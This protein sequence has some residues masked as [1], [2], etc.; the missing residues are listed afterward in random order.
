MIKRQASEKLRSEVQSRPDF[1]LKKLEAA[2]CQL[3][4]C[5]PSLNGDWPGADTFR[6]L[7]SYTEGATG[8]EHQS[9]VRLLQELCDNDTDLALVL[10]ISLPMIGTNESDMTN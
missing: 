9:Q 4:L 2:L 3:C 5:F 7:L 1:F 6:S 10:V 8:R